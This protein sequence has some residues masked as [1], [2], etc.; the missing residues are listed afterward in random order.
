M[1]MEGD[2]HVTDWGIM[3]GQALDLITPQQVVG[4]L[5]LLNAEEKACI[6]LQPRLEIL[7]EQGDIMAPHPLLSQHDEPLPGAGEGQRCPTRCATTK[8]WTGEEDGRLT[9]CTLNL[10]PQ[11]YAHIYKPPMDDQLPPL[12]IAPP[13]NAHLPLCPAPFSQEAEQYLEVD[14]PQRDSPPPDYLLDVRSLFAPDQDPC[15][16]FLV[17]ALE[18]H[19]APEPM[20]SLSTDLD[21]MPQFTSDPGGEEPGN[22]DQMTPMESCLPLKTDRPSSDGPFLEPDVELLPLYN[23]SLP[24]IE[25]SSDQLPQSKTLVDVQ[26]RETKKLPKPESVAAIDLLPQSEALQ[27]S[28]FAP[29]MV[30]DCILLPQSESDREPDPKNLPL[31]E[32]FVDTK[33]NSCLGPDPEPLLQAESNLDADPDPKLLPQ[34]KP[35]LDPDLEHLPQTEPNLLSAAA[36]LFQTESS[37]DPV[38]EQLPQ[39]ELNLDTDL[40]QLPQTVLDPEQLPH[41]Q[42]NLDHDPEHLSFSRSIV[43]NKELSHHYLDPDNGQLSQSDSQVDHDPE[44]LPLTEPFVVTKDLF[45]FISHLVPVTEMAAQ[46][47]P[48]FHCKTDHLPQF[49]TES[50]SSPVHDLPC[51]P[52]T[53]SGPCVDMGKNKLLPSPEI[54]MT[55]DLLPHPETCLEPNAGPSPLCDQHSNL[56][57]LPHSQASQGCD[58]DP[59]E[60]F[61]PKISHPESH[62]DATELFETELDP[63][64][65]HSHHCLDSDTDIFNLSESFMAHDTELSIEPLTSLASTTDQF[66][67]PIMFLDP[68]PLDINSSNVHLEELPH[69]ESDKVP[70]SDTLPFSKLS[71]DQIPNSGS[72]LG[73]DVDQMPW[74][75]LSMCADTT[76]LPFSMHSLNGGESSMAYEADELSLCDPFLAPD[77][78]ELSISKSTTEPLTSGDTNLEPPACESSVDMGHKSMP[79]PFTSPSL[80]NL[81]QSEGFLTPVTEHMVQSESL[82][83]HDTDRLT[84]S[85]LNNN[86][87]PGFENLLD[88]DSVPLPA[89]SGTLDNEQGP[90][91][92][93]DSSPESEA[94]L[95]MDDD[96]TFFLS[97]T[98]LAHDM[99]Q[100]PGVDHMTPDTD[101]LPDGDQTEPCS[102]IDC[103]PLSQ[104]DTC[105][106]QDNDQMSLSNS[107]Q[108]PL[109]KFPVSPQNDQLL[110]FESCSDRNINQLPKTEFCTP[111]ENKSDH[112][113]QPEPHLGTKDDLLTQLKPGLGPT[114][115]QLP[116]IESSLCQENEHLTQLESSLSLDDDYLSNVCLDSDSDQLSSFE[117]PLCPSSGQLSLTESHLVRNSDLLP[118]LK[119]HLSLESKELSQCESHSESLSAVPPTGHMTQLET[120]FHHDF[121]QFSLSEC[122]QAPDM[123]QPNGS[124][125]TSTPDQSHLVASP[126]C[127]NTDVLPLDHNLNLLCSIESPLTESPPT[128]D[129]DH[130]PVPESFVNPTLN[131]LTLSDPTIVPTTDCFELLESS[132]PPTN[133]HLLPLEPSVEHSAIHLALFDQPAFSLSSESPTTPHIPP[134]ET[135]GTLTT[136]IPLCDTSITPNAPSGT[137][138]SNRTSE[139]F[140]FPWDWTLHSV[141]M[142][143]ESLCG[144]PLQSSAQPHDEPDDCFTIFC[145]DTPPDSSY[146]TPEADLTL[147]DDLLSLC[148]VFAHLETDHI[149]HS[150]NDQSHISTNGQTDYRVEGD[151]FLES[152]LQDLESKSTSKPHSFENAS[153]SLDYGFLESESDQLDFYCLDLL[154]EPSRMP[155]GLASEPDLQPNLWK[156]TEGVMDSSADPLGMCKNR[157]PPMETSCTTNNSDDSL[158]HS[159]SSLISSR[160]GQSRSQLFIDLDSSQTPGE[161]TQVPVIVVTDPLE[162]LSTSDDQPDN[163][164]AKSPNDLPLDMSAATEPQLDAHL[165][166][167]EMPPCEKKDLAEVKP[168]QLSLD[169]PESTELSL[170]DGPALSPQP[171]SDSTL[172]TTLPVFMPVG[173]LQLTRTGSPFEGLKLRSRDSQDSACALLP[174][175]EG[176]PLLAFTLDSDSPCAGDEL[177]RLRAVFDALDRDKDGFVKMED[178][179]Q[180]ATVYGAEQVKYL[181]GYL[182]PA[183]LGVINFRDFYRG[184][185]EIQNED[186]DMQLYDMGYP[187]EEEPACSVDFDDLAAFEVTEV[188]DSAYVGSESA[189]SECETFT[190]EDTGGLAAHED[191]ETEGDGAGSRGHAPATPEGLELSLSDISGVTVTGQEE[192]FEDFGEGAEPDLFNSHSEEEQES[193]TQTTNT[194]HRL[195]SSG[196][197]VSERQLLAPPP[198]TGLGGLYCSQC[199]KHINRL[200]DLSTRLRYLEM[201]SP[202]KR[203]SSRKE[204]RRLHHSGLLGEDQGEPPLTNMSFDDT[205]LTDKVLYLEQRVSELERDAA[206]TGEQQNRLKQ[207]NLH[208]LHRAHALEEQL[209]DQEERSDEVQSEETRKHRDELRKMERD[210]GFRLSSLKARVHEL[211][212]ENT[213]LRSQLPGTKATAQRLEEEKYKLMDEVE[214]LQRQ[215]KEHQEQNKKL[216]GK[217]SKEKHKQQLEKER[218]QEVIEELR[219]E[220]EQTQLLRLEMEQ[221]LGL[222]NSTALQEY[223]SRTRESELEQEV[224]RLKQEQRILKEQNEE[225]NGQII[226]LSIQGAKNL[227]STTFSDSLAAEISSVSRD[228]LMEAIQKQE[229]INLRLQ[230]YIDRIIVAIMET[231]PA[232]LEVK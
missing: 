79:G 140:Q 105:L 222:G 103:D 64:I 232:I 89:P 200:E 164:L 132:M 122:Q 8:P 225:L 101:Q 39:T 22:N 202:D 104:S 98:F 27:M 205:Y 139:E 118:Q 40:K 135:S 174:F 76:H 211:E 82:L 28:Q 88:S 6:A 143:D 94:C 117:P 213:E 189:Y 90:V 196:G 178:F 67:Q 220:L 137:H 115:D 216:G 111:P 114:I 194:S 51:P 10:A 32:S 107:D 229:E 106:I 53:S 162:L 145:L 119:T 30:P 87:I 13:E 134:S 228:E 138:L 130:F 109:S 147:S 14:I 167:V 46:F 56:E 84:E 136:N 4:G 197:P 212:N 161:S 83:H 41:I 173:E 199:H 191:Q 165:P 93:L 214:E 201:D 18:S 175:G 181:T 153:S 221:R 231:N 86:R 203:P 183:G 92:E 75:E 1:K 110:Q 177:A 146:T 20:N 38:P 180:F 187:S 45:K 102:P 195:T 15:S 112:L 35:N 144:E 68:S 72:I 31:T 108:L 29:C 169:C 120:F 81:Q 151:Q 11:E 60:Y 141:D 168:D 116:Q 154:F 155:Q 227:F 96:M 26:D 156:S 217:L 163:I 113:D 158:S 185:S 150:Q 2:P 80:E 57:N 131:T 129:T 74:F 70:S 149:K 230:D 121:N 127:P 99:D 36:L 48:Y 188:T 133:A 42:S 124:E 95:T 190:D 71:V 192:Q 193:F 97:E 34:I 100:I 209:K 125:Q 21:Q 219:R 12:I 142:S 50:C 226:N 204:A 24:Q 172:G 184:I 44:E 160:F 3:R 182:D 152:I 207:E 159:D 157:S 206:M 9:L 186:L 126:S 123:S 69:P 171:Q 223:N 52:E 215:L 210:R 77:H 59:L 128:S 43:D 55:S 91:L 16:D 33:I 5:L 208:L 176:D 73:P 66:T 170:G 7:D 49:T 148:D 25:P 63:P 218:C 166:V 85:C 65:D 47:E 62:L 37:L 23:P 78:F 179:V 19:Q 224:R 61:C 54:S 198:C 17:S 58:D